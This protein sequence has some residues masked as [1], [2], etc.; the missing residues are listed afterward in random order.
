MNKVNTGEIFQIDEQKKE[1]EE[2]SIE[3][4]GPLHTANF[5][6]KNE[7]GEENGFNLQDHTINIRKSQSTSYLGD[8]IQGMLVYS[9]F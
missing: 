1:E 3:G 9:P 5:H 8:N 6:S 4:G 7:D 2:E